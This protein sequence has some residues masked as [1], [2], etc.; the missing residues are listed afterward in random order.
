MS[1]S[2]HTLLTQLWEEVLETSVAPDDDFFALG[3]DSIKAA[4]IMNR[5]Q[6]EMN[7]I[8][9]PASIFAAPTV[10]ELS[11]YCLNHYPAVF[12][13][14]ALTTTVQ[15]V[16]DAQI[17]S[18][19][20]HLQQR[21][22]AEDLQI[23]T[24]EPNNRQA[25]FILCPPRSG[26]TLL[27]VMLA[28]SPALFSPPELYLLSFNTLQQRR[29]HF[30]GP[31]K[32]FREGLLRALM[33]LKQ[34]AYPQAEI[35]LDELEQQGIS[36]KKLYGLMQEWA[37][38]RRIIDKTPG[39]AFNPT[40]LQRAE[41]EFTEALFIHLV[42]HPMATIHSFEEIRVDLVTQDPTTD[43]LPLSPRQKGE[44]WWLTGHRNILSF[45]QNVPTN[46]QFRLHYEDLV[47]APEQSIRPLCDFLNIPFS[48]NLLEP[49]QEKQR[50]MTDGVTALGKTLGDQKFH[51]HQTIDA[52]AAERWRDHYQEDFLCDA[53]WT[54][55]QSL[56]YEREGFTA[57]D[58][59][60]EEW[61]I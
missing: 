29:E 15:M 42:R 49:Y 20:E 37:G 4:R 10:N 43:D 17:A 53:S 13:Q 48:T 7:A 28:G 1:T 60:R 8:F 23:N 38:Q 47:A 19:K 5:L 54:L 30:S 11:A 40:S 35:L 58:E 45:L 39:Y 44:L 21:N 9:H 36:T 51:T 52:N 31:L 22:V 6:D 61:E 18:A 56:G 57:Q 55:A 16:T 33:E 46:R 26:S 41:T 2:L 12:A 3:G 32:F 14:K 27:R 59:T 34:H 25:I 50:R 24:T